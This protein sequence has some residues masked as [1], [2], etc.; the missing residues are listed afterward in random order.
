M[1]SWT[2]YR[3]LSL[4]YLT[5][6]LMITAAARALTQPTFW[7]VT[8]LLW[9]IHNA[10]RYA[11]AF[12]HPWRRFSLVQQEEQDF[13]ELTFKSRDGL[14][15]FGRFIASRND[16]TILLAHGLGS[17]S[18]D[19]TLLGRLLVRAGYG[20]FLLDLRAH[21]NSQGDTST[22]GLR[23]GDDIVSA[24]E[25]LLRRID[26]HGDKIGAYGVSLGAQ[27]VLRGA[28][29]TDKIRAL[30][31]ESLGPSVLGDHG[32]TPKSLLRWIN[33]PFNWVYYLVYQFMIGGRDQGVLQ[34]IG[35][36]AP[37]PIFLIASG[38]KDIYFN[39][40]FFQA[41]KD[42]RELWELS[43][44]Q[45]GSALAESPDEYLKRMIA[46]FDRTLGVKQES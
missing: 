3:N 44:G 28:L 12:A 7:V 18:H 22:F 20:V 27:V 1:R 19:M 25:Y 41:A 42:P 31:L 11:F 36:I 37:R 39:R 8:A 32:G 14:N 40:L 29:K 33:Y 13:K 9:L 46:F 17:S 5:M 2:Y 6:I 10:V 30:M 4:F 38:D 15:L 34:V 43:E 35:D 24:V 21:G 16:A 26:V 45:H 23:E